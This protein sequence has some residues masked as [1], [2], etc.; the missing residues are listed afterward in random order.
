MRRAW[1]CLVTLGTLGFV[2]TPQCALAALLVKQT[3]VRSSSNDCVP[4]HY[5][6]PLNSTAPEMLVVLTNLGSSAV[7][8][9]EVRLLQALPGAVDSASESTGFEPS[10]MPLQQATP[11]ALAQPQSHERQCVM[12]LPGASASFDAATIADPLATYSLAFRGTTWQV[13]PLIGCFADLARIE[14]EVY[15]GICAP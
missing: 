3:V 7:L 1:N 5:M 11:G 14:V 8:V 2:L 15:E 4:E 13:P 6:V 10:A 9:D 12:L